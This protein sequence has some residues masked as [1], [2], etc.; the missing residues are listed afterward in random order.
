MNRIAFLLFLLAPA[1][2]LLAQDLAPDT[3][4]GNFLYKFPTGWNPL[5]KGAATFIYA[6][7][8]KPG[9]ATFIALTANDLEGDL[10]NSFNALLG[11]LKSSYRI[12][13]GGQVSSLHSKN[14]FDAFYTTLVATDKSGVR[15]NMY[16]LG[17][18]YRKRLESVV[19]MSNLFPFSNFFKSPT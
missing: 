19:F 13:Q 9:T 12:E 11:G 8:A 3:Q 4:T 14:H 18:Q 16:I 6:P 7:L 5:E 1:P 17:A 2:A 15:W 10:Q